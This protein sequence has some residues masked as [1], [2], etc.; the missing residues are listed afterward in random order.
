MKNGSKSIKIDQICCESWWIL[1]F[2]I[3]FDQFWLN[4]SDFNPFLM[5]LDPLL[6]DFEWYNWIRIRFHQFRHNNSIGIQEFRLKSRL[7]A[8]SG[9]NFYPSPINRLSL[10]FLFQII[11]HPRFFCYS[12][13]FCFILL[14]LAIHYTRS[15]LSGLWCLGYITDKTQSMD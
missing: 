12:T 14:S 6:I 3:D 13:K 2:L 7:K 1:F 10:H 8:D 4:S 15:F 11:L 9:Q 5:D